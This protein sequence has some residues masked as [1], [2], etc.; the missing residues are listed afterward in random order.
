[1]S[2]SLAAPTVSADPPEIDRPNRRAFLRR[3]VVP[4]AVAAAG[5]GAY[6]RWVE[7]HWVEVVER[8]MA[9]E[10]LPESLVGKRLVQV[11]DLHAG[12]LVPDDYLRGAMRRVARLEP[13][14]LVVTGDLMTCRLDEQVA[15]AASIVGEALSPTTH[16]LAVLGNHDFGRWYRQWK[17]AGSLSER[18]RSAGV[19]V[20]RNASVELDGLTFAG[21]GDLWAEGCDVGLALDGV[22]AGKP[23]IALAHNPDSVDL[24]GWESFRGW[25]LSG[26]THGG[27][28]TV[29]GAYAP[30]LPVRNK[31][32]ASG[33]V[34]LAPGR[35][36][37]VNRGLGYIRQVRFFARPEVTVFTLARAASDA[38]A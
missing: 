1:L 6:A 13:D 11:S 38:R 24:S 15:R 16:T 7:P 10:N 17:A 35:D 18:L 8:T 20:L 9:L 3:L 29:L 22:S 31:R 23:A 36:L 4:G 12:P 30:V 14:Y 28:C 26:H 32:Y 5:V 21:V 37:Y 2:E 33:H 25:T 27:Q 19:H 34:A